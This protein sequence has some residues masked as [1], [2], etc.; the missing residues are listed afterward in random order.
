MLP[1][2]LYF[3]RKFLVVNRK[4]SFLLEIF[5]E[6]EIVGLTYLS[7][8]EYNALLL[9]NIRV[10]CVEMNTSIPKIEKALGYGNGAISGWSKAKRYAPMSRIEAVAEYLGCTVSEL[11]GETEK[12]ASISA[13]GP[14]INPHYFSI[15]DG[16]LVLI[17][18]G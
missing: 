6:V 12:P 16:L 15:T 3:T 10:R 14:K 5:L 11:V 18:E 7:A 2:A 17:I 4:S 8:S 13:D 1:F 9:R